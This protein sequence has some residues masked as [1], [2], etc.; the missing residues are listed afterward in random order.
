MVWIGERMLDGRIPLALDEAGIIRIELVG[1]EGRLTV[2]GAGLRIEATGEGV[3]VE[4]FPG[5]GK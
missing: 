2:A 4:R 1:A 5:S 3:Y